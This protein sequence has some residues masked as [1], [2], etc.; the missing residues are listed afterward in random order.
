MRL[1]EGISVIICCYN[2]GWIIARCLE[3]LKK[4]VLPSDINWEVVL[5]D[6]NCTDDTVKIAAE[7]MRDSGI[8]FRIVEEKEPGLANARE[9]GISEVK[10]KYVVYCDD[11]NLLCSNYLRTVYNLFEVHSDVGAIGGKGIAEFE[12]EPDPRI[13]PGIEGYAIGSQTNHKNW[14]FGAGMALRTELVRDVYKSQT[15]FLVGRMGGELLAGDDTELSLSVVIRGFKTY[16]TDEISYVHVLR[17]NRLTW[18]YNKK[19]FCGFDKSIAPLEVMR[20]VVEGLGIRG[21]IKRCVSSYIVY[22]KYLFLFRAKRATE[23]RNNCLNDIRGFRQWGFVKLTR[24][25]VEWMRIKR[26]YA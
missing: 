15:R 12:C 17:S 23:I 20:I 1:L 19:M 25:Y 4:Q 14:L 13:L 22:L 16:P 3:A 9:K 10:Y 21:L 7:T 6:N 11:D 2:S 26:R 5:V 24:V 18:E 8:D